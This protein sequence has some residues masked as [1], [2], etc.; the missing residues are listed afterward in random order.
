MVVLI[1][2][3]IPVDVETVLRVLNLPTELSDNKVF[4]E[5][6]A[7]VLQWLFKAIKRNIYLVAV[8]DSPDALSYENEFKY[9]YCFYLLSSVLEFINLK[10]LG[11]GI[12]KTT[13][14]D[15]Q[16]TQLLSG[17]EIQSFK[18]NLEIRALEALSTHLNTYGKSRLKELKFGKNEAILRFKKTRAVVI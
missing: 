10:T 13:G 6:Q 12:I 17:H 11:S 8:S 4:S 1:M 2:A 14:I 5:H 15:E 7:N 18:N 16:S 3:V 9:A